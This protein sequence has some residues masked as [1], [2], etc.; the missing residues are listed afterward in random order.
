[1]VTQGLEE[2]EEVVRAEAEEGRR[3]DRVEKEFIASSTN[4]FTFTFTCYRQLV[5]IGQAAYFSFVDFYF[6]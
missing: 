1:M 4:F 2:A 5:L 3:Q 6:C